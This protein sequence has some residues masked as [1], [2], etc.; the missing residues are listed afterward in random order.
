MS[1][2][3]F[4][5]WVKDKKEFSADEVSKIH[6]ILVSADTEYKIK[7]KG[8]SYLLRGIAL[9]V[10]VFDNNISPYYNL[11]IPL[12]DVFSCSIRD[13]VEAMGYLKGKNCLTIQP[14]GSIFEDVIYEPLLPINITYVKL[15]D[16]LLSVPDYKVSMF[17]NE[18]PRANYTFHSF[19][20]NIACIL[21]PPQTVIISED[22]FC[23][24]VKSRV[25]SSIVEMWGA[26]KT[27]RIRRA[28]ADDSVRLEFS[29]LGVSSETT[30]K[31]VKE[32]NFW[33]L[34]AEEIRNGFK[35]LV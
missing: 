11:C 34:T 19:N 1:E 8:Y 10:K 16:Y 13:K 21:R 26:D 20:T 2:A 23:W 14:L 28:K 30:P 22:D 9:C 35:G 17:V 3:E 15:I 33:N 25:S 5:S 6:S 7:A 31:E 18:L 12:T 24:I 4:P 29:L 27:T 32:P